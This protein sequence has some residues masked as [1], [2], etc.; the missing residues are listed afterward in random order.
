MNPDNHQTSFKAYWWTCESSTDNNT[1]VWTFQ[2]SDKP[3]H[4][5]TDSDSLVCKRNKI[6]KIIVL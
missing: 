6:L 3:S 4:E 5:Y 2:Q 1:T